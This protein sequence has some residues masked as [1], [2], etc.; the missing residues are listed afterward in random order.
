MQLS[1]IDWERGAFCWGTSLFAAMET[2]IN[3]NKNKVKYWQFFFL[4]C[5]KDD[6][7]KSGIGNKKYFLWKI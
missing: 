7:E 4:I 3:Q 6:G 2:V 5:L 1:I